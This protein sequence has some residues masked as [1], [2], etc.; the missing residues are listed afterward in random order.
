[1]IPDFGWVDTD[2]LGIDQGLTVTMIENF[3]SGFIWRM[4]RKS[5]YI[6]RGLERAGFQGGWLATGG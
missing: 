3:R 4:M 5:P 1:V 6:R 2:Y